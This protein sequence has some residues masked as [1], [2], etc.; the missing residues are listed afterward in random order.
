MLPPIGTGAGPRLTQTIADMQF[1]KRG[2]IVGVMSRGRAFILTLVAYSGD[3]T[4][5]QQ[6]SGANR[7]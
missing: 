2:C 6:T 4:F 5:S 7:R 3:N 1:T